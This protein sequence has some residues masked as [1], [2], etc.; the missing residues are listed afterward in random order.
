MHVRSIGWGLIKSNFI[1]LPLKVDSACH[2][3]AEKFGEIRQQSKMR[4]FGSSV[5][6]ANCGL[7]SQMWCKMWNAVYLA[8]LWAG[9]GACTGGMAGALAGCTK[10]VLFQVGAV[11]TVDE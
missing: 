9:A 10:V 5:Q 6:N 3:W 1:H 8:T 2:H 7:L 4:S 11:A